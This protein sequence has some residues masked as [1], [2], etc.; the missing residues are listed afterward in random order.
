MARSAGCTL[1]G[2]D[3]IPCSK[4]RSKSCLS[5][6]SKSCSSAAGKALRHGWKTSYA[7]GSAIAAA[8]RCSNANA[9]GTQY[10]AWLVPYSTICAGLHTAQR[11]LKFEIELLVIENLRAICRSSLDLW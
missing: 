11:A 10:P 3:C 1:V 7:P 2:A 6:E 9:R 5:P 4:N 8:M